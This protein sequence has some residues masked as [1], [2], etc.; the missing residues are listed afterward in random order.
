LLTYIHIPSSS[1]QTVQ[2][3]SCT[4]S[5]EGIRAVIGGSLESLPADCLDDLVDDPGTFALYLDAD[6]KEKGLPVN[7]LASRLGR[8]LAGDAIVGD[9]LL[10]RTDEWGDAATLTHEQWTEVL[11]HV[12]ACDRWSRVRTYTEMVQG[13]VDFLQGRLVS[14]PC[15]CG[16]LNLESVRIQDDLVHLSRHGLLTLG[17]QPTLH[18]GVWR[19]R[20]YL[21]LYAPD[22]QVADALVDRLGTTELLCLAAVEQDL[23]QDI[24][25]TLHDG[26]P[27]TFA[28]RLAA[29]ELRELWARALHPDG[30]AVV[31][32]LPVL[33]VIDPCWTGGRRLWDT[34]R[35]VVDELRLPA[36]V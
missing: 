33:Q 25:V 31:Q 35:E 15:H 16:P 34:M 9:A 30:A 11:A 24:P 6:G 3:A 8:L 2:L 27:C 19:Q 22:A 23:W 4:D 32:T 1:S 21:D 7:S 28:G 18:E 13:T 26:V 29:S 14:T 20:S 12:Q 17:S 36:L 5:L 10:V